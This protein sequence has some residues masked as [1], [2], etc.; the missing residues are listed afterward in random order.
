MK[1]RRMT[2]SDGA[3]FVVCLF[4]C[5][6]FFN[7]AAAFEPIEL[8]VALAATDPSLDLAV[9]LGAG[10]PRPQAFGVGARVAGDGWDG[11]LV[12]VG[13]D[14]VQL[15]A[16]LETD[17]GMRR[18]T[19]EVALRR[20]GQQWS[21][22]GVLDLSAEAPGAVARP[23]I[24]QGSPS[25]DE[26]TGRPFRLSKSRGLIPAITEAGDDSRAPA[27]QPAP[28]AQPPPNGMVME[29]A[30]PSDETGPADETGPSGESPPPPDP[31]PSSES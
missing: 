11:E 3:V 17:D 18:V 15:D 28:D 23:R 22:V 2:R 12:F 29:T 7:A 14:R 26:S 10:D 1:R 30:G 19:L 24:L 20:S 6:G 21:D 13:R 31:E 5:L 4:C 27:A 25:E 16:D 9:F 8:P